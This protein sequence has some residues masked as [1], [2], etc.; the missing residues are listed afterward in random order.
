MTTSTTATTTAAASPSREPGAAPPRRV[1]P[2]RVLGFGALG[3]LVVAAVVA[4]AVVPEDAN[5]GDAQRIMYVHVPSVWTAYL[6]FVVTTIASVFAF[7]RASSDPEAAM[8]WDRLAGA[9]AEV[10]V[11]FTV[12][13]LVTGALWGRPIWGTYWTWDARLTTSAILFFLYVGYLV[14]RRIDASGS[15]VKRNAI[16]ALIAF[17]D[18]PIVHL[19]V[20]WWT[21]LHQKATVFDRR[22]GEANISSSMGV[23]LLVATVAFTLL[24]V[25]LVVRRR[26]LLDLEAG[27]SERELDAAIRARV[28]EVVPA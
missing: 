21:T 11:L 24:Y 2:V 4:L 17:V 6:A 26:D 12:F 22:L 7:R 18:V 3:A 15:A 25:Y 19:S 23:A 13:M 5:Q 9:S 16:L 27:A 10:G 8:A 1:D 28:S 20:D 14:V